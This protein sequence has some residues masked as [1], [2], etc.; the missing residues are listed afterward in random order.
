[1]AATASAHA[2]QR[3]R[4]SSHFYFHCARGRQSRGVTA[5]YPRPLVAFFAGEVDIA[6]DRIDAAAAYCKRRRG[7]Q[8]ERSLANATA[9]ST[10]AAITHTTCCCCCCCC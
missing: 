4:H 10:C 8:N 1:M 3:W 5:Q 6:Y 2:A 9:T 7:T